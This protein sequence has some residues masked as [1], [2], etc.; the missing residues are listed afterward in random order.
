MKKKKENQEPKRQVE[1]FRE[2]AREHEADQAE[3]EFNEALRK[4]ARHKP[5]TISKRSKKEG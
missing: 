2:T 4:V 3:A 5:A 1:T